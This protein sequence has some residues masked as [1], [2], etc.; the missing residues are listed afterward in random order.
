MRSQT[1]KLK[2][3]LN[4]YIYLFIFIVYLAMHQNLKSQIL[5]INIPFGGI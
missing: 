1:L 3:A 2:M 5:Y 4:I